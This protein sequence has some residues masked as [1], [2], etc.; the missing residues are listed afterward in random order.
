MDDEIFKILSNHSPYTDTEKATLKELFENND[1]AVKAALK[2][3][4][5]TSNSL[6]LDK[7]LKDILTKLQSNSNPGKKIN[8]GNAGFLGNPPPFTGGGQ[9]FSKG[10]NI[11][12][13]S[14][15]HFGNPSAFGQNFPKG[16]NLFSGSIFGTPGSGG[17]FGP[18]PNPGSGGLFEQKPSVGLFGISTAFNGVLG[19]NFPKEPNPGSGGFFGNFTE[20]GQNFQKGQNPN[21]GNGGLFGNP[22]LLKAGVGQNIEI[23]SNSG[24]SGLFV[25]PKETKVNSGSGGVLTSGGGFFENTP[26]KNSVITFWTSTNFEKTNSK[27]QSI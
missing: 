6:S 16:P 14:G 19:Q 2:E 12:L 10:Q 18:K 21:L 17:L 1:I 22:P 20:G 23:N 7:D 25:N 15:G 3:F 9:N 24:S 4:M 11:N 13:G 5:Q 8:S 27:I 26:Q